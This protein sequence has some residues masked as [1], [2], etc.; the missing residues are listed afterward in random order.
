[1]LMTLARWVNCYLR[2]QLNFGSRSGQLMCVVGQN[3]KCRQNYLWDWHRSAR[4]R[5]DV[6][7]NKFS[8]C[9]YI[10][11]PR[12]KNR[13]MVSD[14]GVSYST[15]RNSSL[16]MIGKTHGLDIM[17]V[18]ADHNSNRTQISYVGSDH[19]NQPPVYG[20]V[21]VGVIG[22]VINM[23]VMIVISPSSLYVP[24]YGVI[25]S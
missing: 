4:G 25:P 10:V 2:K 14:A 11:V 16:E 19:V 12:T 22:Y 1:M 7:M 18:A 17:T 24:L 8:N 15:K 6:N 23:A 20:C 5:V 13:E 21:E 9:T 3:R